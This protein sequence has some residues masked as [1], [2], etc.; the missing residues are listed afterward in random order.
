MLFCRRCPAQL[1]WPVWIEHTLFP[2]ASAAT[3]NLDIAGLNCIFVTAG[4]WGRWMFALA[5]PPM[6]TAAVLS[7]TAAAWMYTH[8][9]QRY[10]GVQ[11]PPLL[12]GVLQRLERYPLRVQRWLWSASSTDIV[13]GFLGVIYVFAVRTALDVFKCVT[14]LDR[15]VL[16]SDT[17]ISCSDSE[18]QLRKVVGFAVA[19]S[20]GVGIPLLFLVVLLVNRCGGTVYALL[21]RACDCDHTHPVLLH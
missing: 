4:W 19:I 5:I 13:L 2:L 15:H 9:R 11:P 20:Y 14:V 16:E 7:M 1:A 18:Y 6:V 10:I 12:A 3:V 21:V 8:L 17:S